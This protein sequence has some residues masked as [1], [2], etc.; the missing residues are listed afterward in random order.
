MV[1]QVVPLY[2][3]LIARHLE[4]GMRLYLVLGSRFPKAYFYT[5]VH[6]GDY[7]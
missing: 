5:R 2:A 6:I 7:D 1:Q 3:M 4:V